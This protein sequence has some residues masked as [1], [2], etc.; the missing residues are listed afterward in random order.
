MIEI[1]SV[2]KTYD[3][4]NRVLNSISLDVKEGE[5]VT[6]LGPSGC[7]KTTLLKM[8][9]KLIPYDEGNIIVKGKSLDE[10]DTIRLRRNIGYVIQQIGLFPHMNIENNIAYVMSLG[11]IRKEERLSRVLELITLV[12]MDRKILKRY[13]G[14]LSGG[15][16]QRVGVARALASDPDIILMDE[17]FGAVDEIARTTLQDELLDLQKELGKT[18]L[19]VT[20]DIEEALKLGS[21][22]VLFNEGRIEQVGTKDQLLFKPES[23]FVK[24]FFR[25]KGFKSILDERIMNCVYEKVL[26]GHKTMSDVYLKLQEI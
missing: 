2:T 4:T 26:T 25:L 6:L 9:N 14:E 23:D 10:W 22:I 11:G 8:I 7:G 19:F 13:P 1:R 15:Q 12:G 18:I 20:H 16:C 24:D 17:P 21:R 3:G 5:F